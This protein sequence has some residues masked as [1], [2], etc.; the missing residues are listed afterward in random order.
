MLRKLKYIVPT[1]VLVLALLLAACAPAVEGE[2]TNTPPAE[3][4]PVA[5]DGVESEEPSEPADTEPGTEVE[6]TEVE[7]E[8]AHGTV[9]VPLRPET[10][11]SLD[12]RSFE[13]L[14]H[15]GIKLAAAP[16]AVMPE[17]S[18][19]VE[20]DSVL[21]IGDHREP[22][23]EIIAAVQP[24]LVIIGQ[25]FAT[26]YDEIKALVPQAAI[27]DVDFDVSE[28]AATP[29]ENLINGLKSS[30]LNLGKIF[31]NNEEAAQLISE[32]DQA[33]TNVK[34][35]YNGSDR[36]MSV[37]V[38]GGTIGFSAPLAGR[39]WGPLYDIFE[40]VP[41][42][43]VDGA[44][45]DHKGDDIHVEA[46][47]QSNPDWIFVLDRD[48]AVSSTGDSAPAQDVIDD[49][50][51]LQN[52][53]AIVEGQIVYAPHDTYTNESIHTYLELFE[54]LAAAFNKN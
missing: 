41:A 38:S 11:V 15:W 9:S 49:S 36:I 13:V 19:Y 20:D 42:L 8:D 17:G 23:L 22:N 5:T 43:E 3:T 40:W 4:K 14:E 45:S 54:D 29:G 26:Y 37:L 44:S 16:K 28:A 31:D 39:V 21:D 50:E 48:A 18:A 7:I 24:D 52:T 6:G 51:A 53:T 1:L 10:V 34:S 25:R 27:I 46:I 32:F 2:Q 35:A 33:V 47:A 30:T 12:S